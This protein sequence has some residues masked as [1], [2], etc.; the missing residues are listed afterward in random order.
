MTAL[1]AWTGPDLLC[2]NGQRA[3]LQYSN[4]PSRIERRMSAAA[5]PFQIS[6]TSLSNRF[7]TAF[8]NHAGVAAGTEEESDDLEELVV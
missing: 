3:P 1:A 2:K 4:E 8:S 6:S 7:P 5:G